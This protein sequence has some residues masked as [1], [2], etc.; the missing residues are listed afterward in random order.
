MVIRIIR[1]IQQTLIRRPAPSF[2]I[3]LY[4]S[5]KYRCFVSPFATIRYPSKLRIGRRTCIKKCTIIASGKGITIGDCVEICD[6]AIIQTYDGKISINNGSAIGPYVVLYG[7][8]GIVIG[9][10]CSI[11][12]HTSIVASNHIFQQR[13][14][15]IRSQGNSTQGILI[16]D[17][18]WIG[19]NCCVLDG[20]SVGQGSIVAAGAV[21]NKNVSP[22]MIVGG[23]PAQIIGQR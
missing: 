9:K 1:T 21:I 17:D 5:V 3:A 4:L 22:Y 6:G 16:G 14:K 11:A 19:A 18:V 15:Y 23:I 10:Y 20:V 8:G 2:I 12:T 7:A 13:D